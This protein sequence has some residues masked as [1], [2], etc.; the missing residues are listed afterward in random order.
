MDPNSFLY[1]ELLDSTCVTYLLSLGTIIF[2]LNYLKN[3]DVIV[4]LPV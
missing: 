2:I 1:P 4:K 3:N